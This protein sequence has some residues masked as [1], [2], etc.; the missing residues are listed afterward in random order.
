M[1]E[2]LLM[3][4]IKLPENGTNFVDY[5]VSGKSIDFGDGEQHYIIDER[6]FKKLLTYL[7][8]EIV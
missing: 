4:V 8:E 7:K 2:V 6:L 5:E 1:E 3:K